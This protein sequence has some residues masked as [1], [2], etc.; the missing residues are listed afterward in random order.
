M[1]NERN[2]LHQ[3]SFNNKWVWLE[4]GIPCLVA[5]PLIWP[6]SR[7]N[8]EKG[9][10]IEHILKCLS[11]CWVFA[12]WR[13]DWLPKG[14]P[15]T[16]PAKNRWKV[17][18]MRKHKGQTIILFVGASLGLRSLSLCMVTCI[19]TRKM[20]LR[21]I[22]QIP[23]TWVRA[24]SACRTSRFVRSWKNKL[25][26]RFRIKLLFHNVRNRMIHE[27]QLNKNYLNLWIFVKMGIR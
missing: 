11:T 10:W 18:T 21:A 2:L 20:C 5:F 26:S 17:F 3:I 1:N 9:K 25:I 27:A 12:T 7:Q 23:S 6:L 16:L 15:R 24:H 14:V 13:G 22:I 4:I 8:K 19:P